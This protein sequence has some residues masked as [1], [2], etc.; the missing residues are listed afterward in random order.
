MR[1]HHLALRTAD[2]AT[3]ERFYSELFELAAMRRDGTRSVWLD[4]GGVILMLEARVEG[5]PSVP[6]SSL[7]LVCF[8]ISPA[9]AASVRARLDRRGVVVEARTKS[10]LYFRDPDG[11]RVGVSAYPAELA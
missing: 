10:T 2:V 6:A 5:E 11:R 8:A 7:E 1:I 4:A 3:L 9:E